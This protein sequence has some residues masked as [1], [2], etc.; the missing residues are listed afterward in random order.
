M[1]NT[2]VMC[3]YR[4]ANVSSTVLLAAAIELARAHGRNFAECFLREH[5]IDDA[6]IYELLSDIKTDTYR[7][8][9][10]DNPILASTDAPDLLS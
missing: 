1:R 10:S 4:M 5:G 7:R 8:R 9:Y 6:V 2:R 3:S